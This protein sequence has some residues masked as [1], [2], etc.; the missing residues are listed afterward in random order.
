HISDLVDVVA[1]LPWV[2]DAQ[3]VVNVGTG[4]GT[5]VN[6]VIELVEAAVGRAARRVVLPQRGFDVRSVILSV[7]RLRSMMV[8]EPLPL[9]AGIELLCA[10]D[11]I[12]P[13][14]GSA[15]GSRVRKLR[16]TAPAQ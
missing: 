14:N 5:S 1:R 10:P 9:A 12:D 7:E 3:I 2:E 11:W 4:I 15:E 8:F 6:D 16:R 13:A